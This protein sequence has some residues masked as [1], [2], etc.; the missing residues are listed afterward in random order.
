MRWLVGVVVFLLMIGLVSAAA[1]GQS[2][3]SPIYLTAL[4]LN[5]LLEL[6]VAAVILSF[7][8]NASLKFLFHVAII[9]LV[10]G[11][12]LY[13]ILYNTQTSILIQ[14][15]LEVVTIFIEG[16]YYAI[17]SKRFYKKA[18]KNIDYWKWIL[19]S[20]GCNA[21]S[22]LIGGAALSSIFLTNFAL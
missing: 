22:F 18:H 13:A 19:L 1:P 21:A 16:T 5:I 8:Y 15:L 11:T 9:N 7:F 4:G 20:V 17:I 2:F 12:A 6:L 10:T 14:I 3:F